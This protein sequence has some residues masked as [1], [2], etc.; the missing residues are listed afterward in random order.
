MDDQTVPQGHHFG[1]TYFFECVHKGYIK[2]WDFEQTKEIE[3]RT[4]EL[5]TLL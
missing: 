4:N 1:A 3:P 2:L 5:D